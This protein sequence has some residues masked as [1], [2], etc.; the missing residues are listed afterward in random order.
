VV[1]DALV[2][3]SVGV[4]EDGVTAMHDATEGGVLGG[5]WEVAQASQVG[6]VVEK[7]KISVSEEAEKICALF[8][9]DPYSAISE[10]TLIITCRPHRS[11]QVIAALQRR[12]ILAAAV[13]SVTSR[14][15]GIRLI[16][17]G[18]D[19]PL[20]HPQVDPFWDAFRRAL[21]E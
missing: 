16:E 14:E 2:A 1:D 11:D 13:G 15:L 17:K 12:G 8:G 18:Q 3:V 10:G 9:M 4:H 5:L 20:V 21:E 7:E 6:L 19:R